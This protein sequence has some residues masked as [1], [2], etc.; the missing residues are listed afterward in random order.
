M[1]SLLTSTSA[2]T[3]LTCSSLIVNSDESS[4][5]ELQVGVLFNPGQL[6]MNLDGDMSPICIIILPLL[7]KN[8]VTLASL[9][10]LM[11][12]DLILGDTIQIDCSSKQ[13]RTIEQLGFDLLATIQYHQLSDTLLSH[14]MWNGVLAC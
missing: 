5:R 14:L 4:I 11:T 6:W 10:M 13:S 1:S 3:L 8:P 12:T 9:S 7:C 2:G